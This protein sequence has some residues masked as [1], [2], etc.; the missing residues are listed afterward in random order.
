M[1]PYLKLHNQANKENTIKN[2]TIIQKKTQMI[3][4]KVKL[5]ELQKYIDLYTFKLKKPKQKPQ[6]ICNKHK[7]MKFT[8]QKKDEISNLRN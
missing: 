4:E 7:D 8:K 2:I 6:K 1:W 5:F 3:K